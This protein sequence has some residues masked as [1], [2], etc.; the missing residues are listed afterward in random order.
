MT[1]QLTGPKVLAIVVAAFGVIIAVNLVMAWKAVSTFPGLEVANSYVS[2]QT[3]DAERKAQI[4]LGW[5]ATPAYADGVL[6]LAVRDADGYP[7]QIASMS[8]LVGRT[9]NVSQDVTPDFTYANGTYT[10]PLHLDQGAWLM[11][12]EAHALDGTLFR[13]RLDFHV[14]G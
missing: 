8:A 12:F 2:S 3:F 9:T 10:A 7:A 5:T 14:R 11:H 4:A 13:Q 1:S 6:T